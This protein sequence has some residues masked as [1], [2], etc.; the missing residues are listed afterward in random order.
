M[1]KPNLET[2]RRL[3]VD[4]HIVFLTSEG[5]RGGVEHVGGVGVVMQLTATGNYNFIKNNL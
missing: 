2:T 3:R 4:Q 5:G 1:G